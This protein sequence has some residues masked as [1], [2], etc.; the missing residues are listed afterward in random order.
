MEKYPAAHL[1]MSDAKYDNK[2]SVNAREG[3]TA[4]GDRHHAA[5]GDAAEANI[6]RVAMAAAD[7]EGL[8]QMV[9]NELRRRSFKSV[10]LPDV[11][12]LQS[13]AAPSSAEEGR[14]IA[15]RPSKGVDALVAASS[16][17]HLKPE[18]IHV[19]DS[20]RVIHDPS[21]D[22]GKVSAASY[23]RSSSAS[24]AGGS[25]KGGQ[26]QDD[27][28]PSR[29]LT[30]YHI[31][32]Q[33]EREYIIQTRTEDGE[34]TPDDGKVLMPDVPE[35]YRNIRL[36]P[37]W[38][39][40]PGKRRKRVHRKSHGKVSFME[41]SQAISARWARLDDVDPETKAYVKMLAQRELEEYTREMEEYKA[42]ALA[43]PFLTPLRAPADDLEVA[44]ARSAPGAAKAASAKAKKAKR[45][46]SGG[47]V[48]KTC[49]V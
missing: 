5:L 35:R 36:A 32:L 15:R 8:E 41:L 29:P 49:S 45:R 9:V 16:L 14:S 4:L 10:D 1:Q 12:E 31:F 44:K 34:D 20:R 21:R 2:P 42:A 28:K 39:F 30:A 19:P 13:L 43:D 37:D 6:Q 27:G 23:R 38:Y 24:S 40:R 26:N 3:G 46:K 33:I 22:R 47:G 18:P 11:S 7:A 25:K 17:G 48:G